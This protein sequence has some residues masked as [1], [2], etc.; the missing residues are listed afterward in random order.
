MSHI[1]PHYHLRRYDSNYF[2]PATATAASRAK[3]IR[4]IVQFLRTYTLDGVDFDWCV[5]LPLSRTH[6]KVALYQIELSTLIHP[7]PP[8][9]G[10]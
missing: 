2:T 5:G 9:Q 4:S 1:D 3:F 8:I 7:Y 6:V 10:D